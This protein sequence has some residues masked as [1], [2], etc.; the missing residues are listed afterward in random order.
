MA[1]IRTTQNKVTIRVTGQGLPGPSGAAAPHAATHEGGADPI[2]IENLGTAGAVGTVPTSDGAGNVTM[3]VPAGSGNVISPGGETSGN[4][5][6]F[7]G[8]NNIAETA[9]TTASVSGHLASTANPHSV[10]AAQ[11]GADPVGTATSAV[12]AHAALGDP[13][14]GY[15]L[16]SQKNAAS[17]YAG[18]DGG[19]KLT[20]SQQVYGAAANT[21]CE[22][23]D[24]RLSDSRAPSGTATGDLSGTYP[25]PTVAGLQGTPV[26]ATGP[27]VGQ[28]L[29]LSGGVW[30]PVTPSAG[31]GDVVGPGS[32]VDSNLASYNTTTGKLI[33]DSGIA[34]TNVELQ[35]NKNAASGY[36]GLD[37]SS[38][39]AGAQQTYGAAANTAC[40]GD[41][42][43]LSD[44]RTPTAHAASHIPGAGDALATASPTTAEGVAN[45][46]GIGTA[47][48]RDD[49]KHRV[50]VIVY[51]NGVNIGQRP[52]I[53]FDDGTNTSVTVTADGPGDKMDIQVD[54]AGAPP[55]GA[56]SGDLAGTYPAPSVAAV[57][58]TTGPTS[59]VIGAIADGQF[60]ARSGG[61]LI[62]STPGG[63]GDVVGP[64]SAVDNRL[65]SF[66]ST[67]GKLIKDSGVLS[68]DVELIANK[69]AASGYAGLDGGS[70]LTGS[71][72]VYGTGANT[73]CEGNDA[74]LSDSRAPNGAATGDLSGT[75]PA[76]TVDGLQGQA[77]S[78]TA[79]DEGQ[80]LASVGGVWTPSTLGN[81]T[82]GNISGGLLSINADTTKYDI[83]A[84]VGYVVTFDINGVPTRTT[85][86]YGPFLA[87]SPP[88]VVNNG[89]T[90][91]FIDPVGPS[92]FQ[93][94]NSLPTPQQYRSMVTLQR[95]VHVGPVMTGFTTSTVPAYDTPKA[96]LD[97]IRVLGPINTGNQVSAAATDLTISKASGTTTMPFVNQRNDRNSPSIRVN[98][99]VASYAGFPYSYR[100]GVGGYIQALATVIDPDQWDDGS[101]TLATVTPNKWTIQRFYLGGSSD[102]LV[103]VYGQVLYNS[104][105]EAVAAILTNV[106]VNPAISSQARWVSA[107]I[108]KVGTTDLSDPAVAEFIDEPQG[109]LGGG[110]GTSVST[111]LGLADTT[112]S[113]YI[114]LAGYTPQVDGTET[115][116][117]LVVHPTAHNDSASAHSAIAH[118]GDL[119]G[120]LG[121][122]VVSALTT[123]TGP[124]SLT[125]G[126]WADGAL[127]RRT[128]STAVG[129]PLVADLV[130]R[131][132][133][134][135]FT[136]EQSGITPTT[137][138]ALTTKDYVDSVVQGIEW[139]DTVLDRDLTAPP[140][141]PTTG[142]RYIVATGG[143]GA[144]ATHDDE[145]AEWDGAAW[146]FTVPTTGMT[147]GIDDENRS[148]RWSG[149]TWVFFGTTIDHGNLA[150][151][152]DDDH[153]QYSL[154]D[155]TR[156]FTGEVAGITP[157]AA[158]SLARKDYVD[159][160][161]TTHNTTAGAHSNRTLSGDLSGTLGA[162]VVAAITVTGPTSLVAGTVADGAVLQRTGATLVGGPLAADLLERDGSVLR[163]GD[164]D[165]NDNSI[166]N[167]KTAVLNG[168]IAKG[169]VPTS[170]TIDFADGSM[171]S[172][173]LTGNAVI[174]LAA[175]AG[176]KLGMVLKISQDP[177]G[178]RVPTFAGT[179]VHFPN[180]GAA[181]A[182]SPGGT[183]VDVIT[184]FSDGTN[185][186]GFF[187]GDFA[188]AV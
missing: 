81:F 107:L 125:I 40:E 35:T 9:V 106:D 165:Y 136:G 17:G 24:A 92:V 79:P 11:A 133:S 59:L 99:A 73:A 88:D 176:P 186:F 68:S 166:D 148:V 15:Q 43:R 162:P 98:V 131:D 155:G 183:K 156:A 89:F 31:S 95:A 69:D 33:K 153:T 23:D 34:Q 67:S 182:W 108:V 96:L 86:N 178:S 117:E 123:T 145:I 20:G 177:T 139:Q 85:F 105:A 18:L 185:Y 149:A 58:T 38:K 160:E 171:Q 63:S 113:S 146:V 132:G 19:S 129:G 51:D 91:V 48:S 64:A 147:V 161:I 49:H 137:G 164:Q 45:S 163:T 157:T 138:A 93:V 70:K 124:T 150:G 47:F 112:T 14:T 22:G 116:L 2:T 158:A 56:A 97:F 13:H 140:G 77:V 36:A 109:S 46:E 184:F 44:A 120:T 62:G 25:A 12:A 5:T 94:G 115:G 142:D 39:L 78:A 30:T 173:T 126:A 28:V 104:L 54:V 172:M 87:V 168:V 82:S 26:S 32:A 100:D 76:P 167:I 169:N 102:T 103:A 143:T 42:A 84:G 16:E 127:L 80:V 21:A 187:A 66:D 27:T 61:T 7:T 135:A 110:T 41:D 181:P 114:G 72:Q 3:Q 111:W 74:R 170:V 128:G 159:G 174:T 121:A 122:S 188:A 90:S 83:A 10:T 8:S 37:G 151:T 141:G 144:W 152:G 134:V 1:V 101:G 53:N 75:Y 71:Q 130:V 50:E 29:T 65:A 119:S 55:T 57:T 180:A 6:E 118:T 179:N 52:R 4:L 154:A 60:L 175:P